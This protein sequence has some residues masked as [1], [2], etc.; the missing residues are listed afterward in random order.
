MYYDW[1]L[2]I[3]SRFCTDEALRLKFINKG[4]ENLE[5]W[6]VEEGKNFQLSKTALLN[7]ADVILGGVDLSIVSI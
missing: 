2:R 5:K 7:R 6:A 4:N 3:K 1:L